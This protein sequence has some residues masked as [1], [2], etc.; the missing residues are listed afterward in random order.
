MDKRTTIESTPS[1]NW[2]VDEFLRGIAEEPPKVTNMNS[3]FLESL[4]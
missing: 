2:L 4:L 1:P 3:V